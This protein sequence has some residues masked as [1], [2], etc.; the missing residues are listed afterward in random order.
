[1]G[2]AADW[3]DQFRRFWTGNFSQLDV[4]LE[5]LKQTD[6]QGGNDD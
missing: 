5:E 3:L 4:L 1:M 6:Q 2:Q